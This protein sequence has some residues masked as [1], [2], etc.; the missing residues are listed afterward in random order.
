MKIQACATGFAGP[1]ATVYALLDDETD[2]LVINKIAK[3][4]RRDRF[5]DCAIVTNADTTVWE[6]RFTDESFPEAIAAF[7][8]RDAEKRITYSEGAK[9]A[10]PAAALQMSKV[11]EGGRKY[12]LS[13]EITNKQIAT[14]MIAWYADQSKAIAD[15][16]AFGDELA[17]LSSGEVLT[18]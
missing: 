2:E 8:R 14:L 9:P 10:D 4:M 3:S 11:D 15:A 18:V 16:F 13:Q 7:Q 1:A 17:R 5:Q 12:E 6:S